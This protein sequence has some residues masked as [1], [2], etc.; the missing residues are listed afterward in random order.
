[1]CIGGAP[2]AGIDLVRRL[3]EH[4]VEPGIEHL[5]AIAAPA[6]RITVA[7]FDALADALNAARELR[8]DEPPPAV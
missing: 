7:A 3:W 8:N 5:V 2:A 1:M 6:G 4:G